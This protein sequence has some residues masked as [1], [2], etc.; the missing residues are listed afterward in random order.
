MLKKIFPILLVLAI[1][2]FSVC[3]INAAGPPGPPGGMGGG[4]PCCWPTPCTC[5]VPIDGGIS[6][7]ITAG[8]ALAGKKIHDLRKKS[9]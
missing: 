4:N 8:L 3:E 1:F 5:P 7:L 6:F 9:L 2:F